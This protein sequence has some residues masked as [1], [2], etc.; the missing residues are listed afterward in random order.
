MP[1]SENTYDFVVVGAGSAGAV[2]ANR[3]SA[4]VHASVLLLEAG[5]SYAVGESP[6]I[7]TDA[8]L[9][10][11]DAEHDWG[12]TMSTGRSDRPIA[13]PRGRTLGGSSAINAAVALRP[14]AADLEAWSSHGID[15][16]HYDDLLPDFKSLENIPTGEERFHGRNG[17]LS[18]RQR[19]LEELT[20]S[21]RA[22]VA[23]AQ[24]HGFALIDD[25]N[26]DE[27]H[28]VAAY[29]VTV[30]DGVRQNTAMAFLDPEVRAR[31][32]LTILSGTEIDRILF[33]GT[34][35]SVVLA[36]DGTRFQATREVILSAGTYGS[37]AILLRSG[38]G[39][40]QDLRALDIDV[41]ADLPVGR[42]LQD[43]PFF[44]N[45]YALNPDVLDMSPAA[46]AIVWDR[47]QPRGAR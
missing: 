43:H 21:L 46:G 29:P 8:A 22:F 5:P 11:G 20:P 40:T 14:R 37:A 24:A 27:Q 7:V 9:A 26:G 12:Y 35:A 18:V 38:V 31:P 32:N 4:N 23:A 34:R 15:G 17:P 44:I 42:R 30:V 47:L 13:A 36:V 3:L 19:S 39:P 25:M 45:A 10:G 1:V 6:K 41:V 2:L 16:W 33:E 28:G